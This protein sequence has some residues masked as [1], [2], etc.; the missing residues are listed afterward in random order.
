MISHRMD[1]GTIGDYN[2]VTQV[3]FE[4]FDKT[5]AIVK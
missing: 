4:C 5:F 1:E 3:L 2:G